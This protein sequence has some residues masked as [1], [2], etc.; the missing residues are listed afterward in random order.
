MWKVKDS[1]HPN[2]TVNPLDLLLSFAH[3]EIDGDTV[4]VVAV[5]QAVVQLDVDGNE[6]TRTV[7]SVEAG[8]SRIPGL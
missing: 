4:D 2:A 1:A 6:I 7:T 8:K 3:R 5:R